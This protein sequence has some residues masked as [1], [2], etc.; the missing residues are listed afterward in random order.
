MVLVF[1]IRANACNGE[2]L[3]TNRKY[4]AHYWWRC[5]GQVCAMAMCSALLGFGICRISDRDFL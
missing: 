2:R 3:L 4:E 5:S 1:S